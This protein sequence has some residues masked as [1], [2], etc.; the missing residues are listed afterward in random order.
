MHSDAM[1]TYV[2]HGAA[3]H[4]MRPD[5]VYRTGVIPPVTG[6]NP[7]E[8]VMNVAAEFTRGPYT[9][10]QLGSAQLLGNLPLWERVK[11][12][13]AAWRARKHAAKFAAAVANA[14][15]PTPPPAGPMVTD[16]GINP[17]GTASQMAP[18]I[19]PAIATRVALLQSMATKNL[20]QQWAPNAQAMISARWNGNWGR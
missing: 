16:T 15:A 12:R 20:P 8:D 13:V 14:V 3:S 17:N 11:L 10:Q 5:R 19:N 9:F 1:S 18:Q 2:R 6:F 7:A 4:F